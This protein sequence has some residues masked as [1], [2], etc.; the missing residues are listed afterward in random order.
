MATIYKL[1]SFYTDSI[2]AMFYMNK[3]TPKLPSPLTWANPRDFG[4]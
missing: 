2:E 1:A 4:A 3:I